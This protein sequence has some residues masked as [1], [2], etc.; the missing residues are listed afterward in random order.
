MVAAI[1]KEEVAQWIYDN[2][3]EA[4]SGR[5]FIA[6]YQAGL[7]GYIENLSD[8]EKLHFQGLAEEWNR[9]GPAPEGKRM[10]VAFFSHSKTFTNI[11]LGWRRRKAHTI[12]NHS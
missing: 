6:A 1:Q 10:C 9:D 11:K 12:S 5:E 7:T 3:T 4:R 8:E 2:H